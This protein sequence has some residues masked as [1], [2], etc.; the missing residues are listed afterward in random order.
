MFPTVHVDDSTAKFYFCKLSRVAHF[1]QKIEKPSEKVPENVCFH[2]HWTTRSQ[3]VT[4][5]IGDLILGKLPLR[6]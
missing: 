6:C 4:R 5:G 1:S 2:A 3:L